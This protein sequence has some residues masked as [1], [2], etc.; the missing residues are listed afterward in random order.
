MKDR[1]YCEINQVKI[2]DV[3]DFIIQSAPRYK[4]NMVNLTWPVKRFINFLNDYGYSGLDVGRLLG[5]TVPARKKVIPCFSQ[6]ELDELF[7]TVDTSTALG[8]RDYA[9]HDMLEFKTALGH[10]MDSYSWNMQ[11]FDRFC[12]RYFPNE[13]TLT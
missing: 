11:S 8:E 7:R 2:E 5:N 10:K 12:Q 13:T 6:A 3:R 1:N 4:G 9:I